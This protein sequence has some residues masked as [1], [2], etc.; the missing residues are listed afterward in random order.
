MKALDERRRYGK[1]RWVDSPDHQDGI[2]KLATVKS[3]SSSR[4]E[5]VFVMINP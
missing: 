4:R 3:I 5:Q 2:W 1:Q